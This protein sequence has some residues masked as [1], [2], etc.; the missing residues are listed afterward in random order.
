MSLSGE[1]CGPFPL[2]LQKGIDKS[3]PMGYHQV[4]VSDG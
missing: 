3:P 2:F 4:E 1:R